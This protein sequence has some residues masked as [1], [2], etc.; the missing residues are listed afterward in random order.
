MGRKQERPGN[1][2]GKGYIAVKGAEPLAKL[3]VSTRLP[4][5]MDKELRAHVKSGLSEWLRRAIAS[6]LEQEKRENLV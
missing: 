2:S 1:L 5:S 3:V 6:Q 4:E